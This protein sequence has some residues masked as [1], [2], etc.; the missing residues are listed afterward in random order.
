MGPSPPQARTRASARSS[1]EASDATASLI[2][3]LIRIAASRAAP[4]GCRSGWHRARARTWAARTWASVTFHERERPISAKGSPDS[5]SSPGSASTAPLT[6]RRRTSCAAP[7]LASRPWASLQPLGRPSPKASATWRRTWLRTWPQTSPPA[8]S[9][10]CRLRKTRMQRRS[11]QEQPDPK[12]SRRAD[13]RTSLPTPARRAWQVAQPALQAGWLMQEVA[14][15]ALRAEWLTPEAAQLAPQAARLA[16]AVPE[17][18]PAAQAENAAGRA[19]WPAAAWSG[20]QSQRPADARA[21]PEPMTLVQPKAQCQRAA[22]W[23]SSWEDA[24]VQSRMAPCFRRPVHPPEGEASL[25][26][27]HPAEVEARQGQDRPSGATRPVRHR[28]CDPCRA[29]PRVLRRAS[30][31]SHRGRHHDRRTGGANRTT[32]LKIRCRHSRDGR[33]SRHRVAGSG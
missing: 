29:D 5:A 6:P 30:R 14:Q 19:E 7:Q 11:A 32:D 20:G 4:S 22:S 12:R 28:R 33:R 23:A 18:C 17:A 25:P 1:A 21:M 26:Q 27:V 24:T 9:R 16:L 15:L 2:R 31:R 13:R 3:A 8:S 10:A